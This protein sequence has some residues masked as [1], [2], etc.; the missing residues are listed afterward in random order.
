MVKWFSYQLS[1]RSIAVVEGRAI[2]EFI[3]T[4][5]APEA[6]RD[7][8]H[9]QLLVGA[10]RLE[11]PL[12]TLDGRLEHFALRM[13]LDSRDDSSG[14][15]D[16]MLEGI[17]A[18]PCFALWSAR[19]GRPRSIA[20]IGRGLLRRSVGSFGHRENDDLLK[21]FREAGAVRT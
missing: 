21:R 6:C 15:Q 5:L 14:S 9:H 8:L 11:V 13:P 20:A 1:D 3:Q 19:T 12:E 10:G 18:R 17:E 2:F 4:A 16:A 7:L